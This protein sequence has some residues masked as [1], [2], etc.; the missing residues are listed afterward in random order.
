M[1]TDT[2]KSIERLVAELIGG[3]RTWGTDIDVMVSG[4]GLE[5]KHLTAPTIADIERFLIHNAKKTGP[6][7]L[8]NGLVVKRRAGRGGATPLLLIVPLIDQTLDRNI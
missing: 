6:L 5:V 1:S 8:R 2:W 7:G 4:W 3:R